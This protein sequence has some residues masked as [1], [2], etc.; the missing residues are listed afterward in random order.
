[1][2]SC[3]VDLRLPLAMSADALRGRVRFWL[4]A[5]IRDMKML[6]LLILGVGPLEESRDCRMKGRRA[7]FFCILLRSSI[8]FWN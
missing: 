6:K 8:D 7:L 1:M 5:V 4:E 3:V 2:S